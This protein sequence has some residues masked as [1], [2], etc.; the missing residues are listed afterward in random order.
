MSEKQIAAPVGLAQEH[1]AQNS[2]LL[3]YDG[4][5]MFL[6]VKTNTLYAWVHRGS[7]PVVRFSPR[8]VRFSRRALQEWIAARCIAPIATPLRR[9]APE[10]R[11]DHDHLEVDHGD[12]VDSMP[13]VATARPRARRVAP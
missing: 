9:L 11:V 6:N 13:D 10:M 1:G 12:V 3:D 4:A 8:M 5:S 7:I 2:D